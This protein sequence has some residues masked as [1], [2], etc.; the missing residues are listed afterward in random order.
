MKERDGSK[1]KGGGRAWLFLPAW[2]AGA[3]FAWRFRFV[4][5]DAY[6]SFRYARNLACGHG[7]RYSPGENPPVEGYSNFLWVLICAL[8]ERAGAAITLWPPLLSAA[9]ASALLFLL[10][11]RLRRRLGAGD[12]PSF[13]A[14]LA[15]ALFPPFAVW[16]TGGLATMPFALLLFLL[17]DR[18]F[19][20]ERPDGVGAGATGVLLALVRVE[21]GGWAAILFV[22]ALL[23]RGRKGG[24]RP[25]LVA[26]AATAVTIAAHL[27]WRF[28]YYGSITPNT[29][30]AKGAL[31]A[32]RLGRGF[33]YVATF[34]LTFLTPIALLFAL[35]AALRRER[36]GI[37][38]PAAALA[39]AFPVYAVLATGDFMSMGRFLVP[40]LPFGALLFALALADLRRSP[41]RNARIAAPVLAGAVIVVGALPAWNVH[42]VPHE[43]RARF[44]FRRAQESEF[45]HWELTKRKAAI[46]S[47][48]G[49]ALR[50]YLEERPHADPRP[51][52]VCGTI[53]ARGYYSDVYIYD[54]HGLVTPEV[55]RRPVA[56][57]EPLQPP[58]HDKRV[59][60]TYFLKDR[61]TVFDMRIVRALKPRALLREC[62]AYREELRAAGLELP[63]L[64]DFAPLGETDTE[65]RRDYVL[66]WVRAPEGADPDAAWEDL[67]DRA[68]KRK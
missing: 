60:E 67:R 15:L 10:F 65:G 50:R 41:R 62:L 22:L 44:Q 2:V 13:A 66:V 46:W 56:P 39:F 29:L 52:F 26:A 23:V 40:G 25:I 9:C 43:A 57:D 31:D 12:F 7:L 32:V 1:G 28:S 6:I 35:P 11:D 51:S 45:E 14:T 24:S 59:P 47:E 16:S 48:E 38:F 63:Y 33:D 49:R 17:F 34:L 58:G 64:V 19:L 18:L 53:G 20:A 4:C 27:A 30:V 8:F 55:A 61:P 5:D 21:G 42:L 54:T 68:L 3:L 36:R 37:G